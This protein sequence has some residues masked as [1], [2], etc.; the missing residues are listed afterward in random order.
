MA[1]GADAVIGQLAETEYTSMGQRGLSGD[2]GRD[3]EGYST[4]TVCEGS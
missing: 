4:G 2:Y 1:M 3:T